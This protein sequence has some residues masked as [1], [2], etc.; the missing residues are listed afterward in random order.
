MEPWSNL[1]SSGNSQK[2]TGL[3]HVDAA[4]MADTKTLEWSS[5]YT[6]VQS[7]RTKR[8]TGDKVLLPQSALE[9]LLSSERTGELPT[10][11]SSSD[12]IPSRNTS[13]ADGTSLARYRLLPHPLTFRLFNP[14]NG[15]FVYAGVQEFSAEE[16]TIGLSSFLRQSLQIQ[17][18]ELP[19]TKAVITIHAIHLAKGTFVSL[20]PLDAGYDTE[21]WKALLEKQLRNNFTTLTCGRVL[22]IS[23]GL[24]N[25]FQFLVDNVGPEGEAICVVDTDLVV[26]LEPLDEEQARETLKRRQ[27]KLLETEQI[28]KGGELTVGKTYRGDIRPGTYVDYDLKIWDHKQALDISIECDENAQLMILISPFSARQRARPRLDEYVLG[29]FFEEIHSPIHIEPKNVALEGA[30][31]LYISAHAFSPPVLQETCPRVSFS[32]EVQ[33]PSPR[34]MYTYSLV[35]EEASAE[36][37]TDEVQCTNCRQLVPQRTLFLHESFCLRNNIVC[38]ICGDVF[39]KNSSEWEEHWHCPHDKSKGNDKLSQ[40]NHYLIFHT[41]RKCATCGFQAGNL[42]QLALHRTTTCPDKLILCQFCHLLVPQQGEP[43]PD[44]SDPEVLLSGLTPHELICGGRTTE[45]HLCNKILRLKDMATHMR[46]HEMDRISKTAPRICANPNCCRVVLGARKKGAQ[47]AMSNE[48]LGLCG[49]CFGPLHAPVYDPEGKALQRRL[50][51]KYLTQMLKGCSK[52]WCRNVYCRTGRTN[53]EI[54]NDQMTTKNIM[55]LMRPL[56]DAVAVQP[57][58]EVNT[59]PIYLCTEE[60]NQGNRMLA[61]TLAAGSDENQGYDLPWFVAAVNANNGDVDGANDWLKSKAPRRAEV[62]S[63]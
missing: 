19:K 14:Q 26:D 32:I 35:D 22:S 13:Q 44:I 49:P 20:R 53:S 2:A 6:V 51:R 41:Q 18:T 7:D 37:E 24:G 36:H 31:H 59:A 17:P 27:R 29:Y 33:N 38:K 28:N 45:C 60:E 9:Q 42:P 23:S 55:A 16:G 58:G 62:V 48:K 43:D 15:L 34:T 52:S 54:P 39:I 25:D 10:R 47:G 57:R 63:D 61:D 3:V 8:L 1:T 12:R 50:E 4:G 21:D 30:T 56:V 11:E 46:H 5:Q 40:T